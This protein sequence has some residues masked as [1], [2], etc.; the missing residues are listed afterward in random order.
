MQDEDD[1]VYTVVVNDEEQH[2][3]WP[4]GRPVPAGWREVGVTGPKQECLTRIE[5][6]WPDIRPLSVRRRLSE[7]HA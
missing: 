7:Q 6:L 1:M 2:S 4:H 5:E 3:I